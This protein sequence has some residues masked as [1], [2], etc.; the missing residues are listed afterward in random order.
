M[1]LDTQLPVI[2]Y[3]NAPDPETAHLILREARQRSPIAMGPYGPEVL[4]Y[5]LVRTV[6]RDT[7]FTMPKGVGLAVQGISSG[8]VWDRVTKLLVSID[9]AEHHRLRRLVSR[10][11]TPRAADQMRAACVDVITELVDA[12]SPG[13]CGVVVEIARPYPVPIICTLLGAPRGDWYLFSRWADDVSKAFG[14]NVAEEAPAILRAWEQLESYVED[15]IAARRCHLTD[16]LISELLRAEDD[17]YRLTHDELVNLVVILLN[18]GTDTTRNQLAAAVQ[19]LADHPDQWALLAER[20]ELAPQAVEELIRHTPIALTTV[21]VATEG[22]ELDGIL[23]PAGTCVMANTASANQDP[24]AYDHPDRLDITRTAAPA[25]LTFG[26]GVHYCLGAHLARVELVEALRVITS[27]IRRPRRVGAAPWKP[28]VG[29]SGPT[30]LSIEFERLGTAWSPFGDA[31]DRK[32][33]AAAACRRQHARARARRAAFLLRWHPDAAVDADDL[34]VHVGVGDQ[35]DHHR[36]QL[37]RLAEAVRKEHGLAQLR[38]E[39]LGVLTLAVDRGVDQPRRHGVHADADR[40]QVTGHR[41]G[42]TDDAALG[43]RVGRLTDLTVERCDAGHV[44]DGATLAALGRLVSAHRR[45][46]QPDA[47]ERADQVDG[48]H[49]LVGVQIVRRSELTVFA[50]GALRPAHTCRI[51]QRP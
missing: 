17:G 49:L 30:T 3:E 15:L 7:R 32:L 43:R 23:I 18:A 34:G 10:A 37:V 11:L 48:E 20:P 13:R 19:V 16:D 9:G 4:T 44:D 36:R 25:I 42:Q 41:Q 28:M 45:R 38:L 51:H 50:D 35:F 27:R 22:V 21:R 6:L 2:S 14:V 12:C 40:G 46:G 8:P 5:D 24:E 39:C 26:G 1:N 47:V 31:S 29:I 33:P